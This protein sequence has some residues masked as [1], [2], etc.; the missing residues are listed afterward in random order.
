ML[1][2]TTCLEKDTIEINLFILKWNCIMASLVSIQKITN[3]FNKD[4]LECKFHFLSKI[5]VVEFLFSWK[6]QK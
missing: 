5:Q 2:T 6:N 1:Y 4:D 3:K